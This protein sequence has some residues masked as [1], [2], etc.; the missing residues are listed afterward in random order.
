MALASETGASLGCSTQ[1]GK[2]L[3]KRDF[4]EWKIVLGRDFRER[5]MRTGMS[6]AALAERANVSRETILN[7]ERANCSIGFDGLIKCALAMGVDPRGWFRAATEPEPSEG[8]AP[9]GFIL[10]RRMW[11]G[12][13]DEL[14]E[15]GVANPHV[16]LVVRESLLAYH[17]AYILNAKS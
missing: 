10:D 17:S 3:K 1:G 6:Q 8:A 7:L 12:V 13:L 4:K 14:L 2:Q 15:A 11:H 16:E 9:E 5:R